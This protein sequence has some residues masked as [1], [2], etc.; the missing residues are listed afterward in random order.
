MRRLLP[1][2]NRILAALPRPPQI[3]IAVWALIPWANAGGNLLLD[4][5]TRSAIW[6]QS[7]ALVF[8]NYAALSAAI[9]ISLWG[10]DRIARRLEELREPIS[11]VL[12]GE[13]SEPFR[14][15]SSAA[16]P[17]AASA[18]TA[19]AFAIGT[20]V[21]TGAAAAALRGA[22]WLVVGLPLWTFLWTYASLLLGLDR[23]GRAQL[24]PDTA[25]VDPT[26]GVRPLGAV[27]FMG[28]WMLLAWLVPLVLT[29]LPDVVG[30]AIGLGLLAGAVALF[31]LSLLR[32]HR[33]MLEVKARELAAARELYAQA[34]EPLRDAGTLD[35]LERQAG[36]LAAADALEKRA[37]ALH[38]W[39]IDEATVARVV[40]VATSVV[41]IAIGR[42][43]LG[44][45][46]L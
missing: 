3:W 28:L 36:L 18:G 45:L 9:V 46:G 12:E 17:L 10:S 20:L 43:I 11:S 31:F 16:G 40:T 41:A 19:V 37:A 21:E 13:P 32:I 42:L 8:L 26:L 6:E 35:A 38:E 39:P 14:R 29:G 33:R 15:V 27:A 22:T 44:P 1:L 23:L 30:V 7:R 4:T 25:R 34:Y 24:D 2:T 5:G